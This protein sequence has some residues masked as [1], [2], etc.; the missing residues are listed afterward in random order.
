MKKLSLILLLAIFSISTAKG[1]EFEKYSIGGQF[2]PFVGEAGNLNAYSK[3]YVYSAEYAHIDMFDLSAPINEHF[4]QTN[5]LFGK[6]HD[7]KSKKFRIFY[8]AGIGV[9]WGV[10][11]GVNPN[12]EDY[13][14]KYYPDEFTTIGI[15]VKA[16]VRYIPFKFLAIGLD[17][18]S[19]FNL[20]KT[21][22][23]IMLTIEIGKLRD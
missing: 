15:P 13:H 11:K 19:N 8:Q 10:K 14:K 18:R 1:Q 9:I 21:V 12:E 2:M 5:L 22:G 7:H 4:Q 20:K 23:D 17:T 6:Y 3:K 16:G